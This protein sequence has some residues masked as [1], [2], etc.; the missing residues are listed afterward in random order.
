[1][2]DEKKRGATPQRRK[3]DPDQTYTKWNTRIRDA[4]LFSVG[5]FGVINE[6]V[7]EDQPRPYALLFLASL[8]GLPAILNLDEKRRDK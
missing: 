3:T 8:L 1:M 5:L 4:L 2:P 7:I 6:L